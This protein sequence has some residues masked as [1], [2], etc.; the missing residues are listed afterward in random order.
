[1]EGKLRNAVN[2]NEFIFHTT[3][4]PKDSLPKVN[5]A[6]LVK[7]TGFDFNDPDISG[8]DI[9]LKLI[10]MKVH[11][12]S[13]RYRFCRIKLYFISTLLFIFRYVIIL[14]MHHLLE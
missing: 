8:P 5:G 3:V 12:L 14:K 7:C 13:S 2:E 4:P 6:V 11:E 9:F 10:S 1:M